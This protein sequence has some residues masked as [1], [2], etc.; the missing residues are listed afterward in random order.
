M[1]R[2]QNKIQLR[3]K[4]RGFVWIAGFDSQCFSF[5]KRKPAQQQPTLPEV[6]IIPIERP[7]TWLIKTAK[8]LGVSLAMLILIFVAI[9]I[10]KSFWR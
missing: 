3:T 2:F 5:P 10:A 1:L 4:T 9:N 8:W 6:G 7:E